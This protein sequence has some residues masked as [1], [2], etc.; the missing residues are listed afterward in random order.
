MKD[1]AFNNVDELKE[2]LSDIGYE[3]SIVFVG[4]DYINAVVGVSENGRVIYSYDKMIACLMLEDD[5][6][7]EEAAEF[8]DYNT[9]RALPYMGS[10]APIVMYD[11][12]I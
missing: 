1:K 6:D 2:Y 3:D 11:I 9:I 4:P 10:M 8:I 7:T 12:N 5:M